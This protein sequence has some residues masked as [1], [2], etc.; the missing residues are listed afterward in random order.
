MS[1]LR[2][3]EQGQVALDTLDDD[4][5]ARARAFGAD[6]SPELARDAHP[7]ARA[8]V[9]D[10]G[11][12]RAGQGLHP[13]RRPA[14]LRDPDPEAGLPHLDDET[15]RDRDDAPRRREPEHGRVDRDDE[16]QGPVM[17]R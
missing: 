17:P 13:D 9:L 3:Y 15:G 4:L 7:P 5:L 2:G 6:R 12:D 14:A 11:A 8:A 16:E 1:L 10:D